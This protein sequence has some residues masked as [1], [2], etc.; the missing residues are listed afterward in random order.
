MAGSPTVQATA[1]SPELL[2]ALPLRKNFAW[3]LTGNVVYAG[4]QWGMLMAI[5]KLGTPAM[6]GQFAL[7][8]AIAG[9][10]FVMS[11]LHLRAVQATDARNEYTFGHYFALRMVGAGAALLIVAAIA[12]AFGFRRETALVVLVVG[13]AKVA[14]SLSDIIYG[15]W[16]KQ[17]RLDKIAQAMMGRGLGSLVALATTLYF[18]RN[19]VLC[20]GAMALWWAFWLLT[21][22]RGVAGQMLSASSASSRLRPTWELG[23]LKRLAW[24]ALPLGAVAILLSLNVNVPRYFVEHYLGEAALGYF[25][26]LAYVLVAGNTVLGALGQSASPRLGRYYHTD[27]Q[28]FV[29]VLLK[30]VLLAA[31]LG[32]GGIL[33]AIFAGRPLLT[34][35]YR[36]EYSQYAPV[37]TWLM[38][39]GA[40]SYVASMLGYAMTATRKFRPQV[41]LFAGVIAINALCCWLFVPRVG[42]HGAA[43]ALL[44]AAIVS[45]IG[46][47]SINLF[48]YRAWIETRKA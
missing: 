36:R 3:T 40:V 26:A 45:C 12:Y 18:T 11:Q 23:P 5:A 35:L 16:Q 30:M 9:P 29:R 14:E 34:L 25:A 13:L 41:P 4:C 19:I 22:E 46:A 21:Y 43:Y 1:H 48:G 31:V 33:V 15:F 37:F 6:L 28:A 38:V 27:R 20:V 39:S 10:V 24:M 32:T 8:L 42:L 7:G 17:E 47:A 44:S 2:Q